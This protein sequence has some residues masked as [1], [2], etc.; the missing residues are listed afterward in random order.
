MQTVLQNQKVESCSKKRKLEETGTTPVFNDLA[1]LFGAL[2]S[3]QEANGET[4][5]TFSDAPHCTDATLTDDKKASSKRKREEEPSIRLDQLINARGA[6]RSKNKSGNNSKKQKLNAFEITKKGEIAFARDKAVQ[7]TYKVKL[8]EQWTGNKLIDIETDFEDMIA[9]VLKIS[10][11]QAKD[12]DLGNIYIHNNKRLKDIP[13]TLRPWGEI[14]ETVVLDQVRKV[15][16]SHADLSIDPGFEITVGSIEIPSGTG[17]FRRGYRLA[18]PDN[19]VRL[20]TRAFYEINNQDNACMYLS[21]IAAWISSLRVVT[22]D[23]WKQACQRHLT[24][25]HSLFKKLLATGSITRRLMYDSLLL[26]RSVKHLMPLAKELCELAG[27]D[28]NVEGTYHSIVPMEVVLG[29]NIHVLDAS[30]GNKVS[31]IGVG[32]DRSLYIY[33]VITLTGGVKNTH[34]H[35]IKSIQAVFRNATFCEDCMQPHGPSSKC[36]NKCFTCKRR[37]CIVEEGYQKTCLE[38]NIKFRNQDCF[39]HHL[40]VN[41][42]GSNCSI[43]FKCIHCD[44]TLVGATAMVRPIGAIRRDVCTAR[45]WS[46]Q[47]TCVTTET[48]TPK[49]PVNSNTSFLISKPGKTSNS[50]VA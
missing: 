9:E 47:I 16:Q 27:I 38:C 10:R 46:P 19:A 29:A 48:P 49:I 13:I 50:P 7:K 23:E 20:K 41:A 43:Y 22:P 40:I 39:D 31:R 1:E 4:P 33:A 5:G 32:Y 28:Y 26:K 36:Q 35:A 37:G 45:R 24:Q 44:A 25:N 42:K 11:G 21:V 18:G 12:T 17:T 2:L 8:S 15:L 3:A 6:G 14:N 30:D 34:Y